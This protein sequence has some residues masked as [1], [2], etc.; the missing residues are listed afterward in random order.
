MRKNRERAIVS[1]VAEIESLAPPTSALEAKRRSL[2]AAMFDETADDDMRA[3]VR[4]QL[5]KAK[6][7]DSKAAALMMGLFGPSRETSPMQVNQA[8]VVNPDRHLKES[9]SELRWRCASVIIKDGPM[10][11]D[12]LRQKLGFGPGEGI[13]ISQALNHDWFEKEGGRWNITNQARQEVL[14]ALAQKD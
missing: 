1:R 2:I 10:N 3:V 13:Y 4:G 9:E 6:A 14:P 12:E 8:V 5:D 7:G 11:G